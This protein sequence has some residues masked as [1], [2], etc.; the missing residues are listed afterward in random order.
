MGV[1]DEARVHVQ[2][3]SES[4]AAP[5]SFWDLR[6]SH[7][8]CR[9]LQAWPHGLK[10]RASGAARGERENTQMVAELPIR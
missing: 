8:L 5:E 2:R 7:A 6:W 1:S 3:E 4:C 9:V 10:D